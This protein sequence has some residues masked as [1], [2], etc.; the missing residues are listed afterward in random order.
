MRRL[1]AKSGARAT[2]S[3]PPWPRAATA[4][5][6]AN[7]AETVPSAATRRSAPPRSVTRKPPSASGSTAHGW[8]RPRATTSSV[9]SPLTLATWRT[10]STGAGSGGW[11]VWAGWQAA[12]A[13]ARAKARAVRAWMAGRMGLVLQGESSTIS[14]R[15]QFEQLGVT[16]ALRHEF[17]MR[18]AGFDP[19][20]CQHQDAVGHAHAG[21][22]VRDQHRGAL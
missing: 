10:C 20:A 17:V 8:D 15:L 3:S 16:P 22:A 19:A 6:P 11:V 9:A 14:G 12:R 13:A 21:K 5:T 18:A 7:G 2:S 4:G 1:W